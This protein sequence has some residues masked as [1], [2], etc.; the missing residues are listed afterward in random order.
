MAVVQIQSA[1]YMEEQRML[2]LA[3]Q[4]RPVGWVTLLLLGS[5]VS[6]I[7]GGSI[8]AL[9][10]IVLWMYAAPASKSRAA[11]PAKSEL[12]TASDFGELHQ[13]K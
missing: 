10:T 8:A 3:V 9:V 11:S 2:S 1:A 12:E 13:S 4:V 7:I 5:A 6:M